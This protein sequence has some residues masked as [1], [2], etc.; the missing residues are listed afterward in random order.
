MAEDMSFFT[1]IAR[2]DWVVKGVMLVLL[3]FSIWCWS[4]VL[5]KW[6]KLSALKMKTGRFEKLFWSG[7]SLDELQSRSE[8]G[9]PH[10]ISM[11]FSN[12][13]EEW[14]DRT[15]SGSNRDAVLSR[16]Q[17]AM[18]ITRNAAIDELEEGVGALAT[19]AAT[20]PFIGLFGTVWGIMRSFQAI[21]VS[22][23]TTLA[24]VAPG[25]AEA[26]LATALGLVAAIPAVI[27][28]NRIANDI[29]R[30]S[31]RLS[32]FSE[33]FMLIMSRDDRTDGSER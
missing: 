1:L 12:A 17:R 29:D 13:M 10:P 33:E 3:I 30:F 16:A 14:R 9:S 26:L 18:D 21:A 31:N 20:A 32:H 11:M 24:V 6:G 8:K 27:F 4:V 28:Y 7:I 2:A 25:I 5:N 23:N 22:K 19:I 15:V